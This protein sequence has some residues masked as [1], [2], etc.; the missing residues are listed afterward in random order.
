MPFPDILQRLTDLAGRNPWG[1]SPDSFI[2][3]TETKAGVPMQGRRFI[4]GLRDALIK[5]GFSKPEAGKYL[6]HGWRHFYTTYLMGKLEKKLLKSQTG[7][8]TDIMLARYGEHRTDGD[9]ELIQTAQVAAFGGLLP[10][11]AIRI[12]E[13]AECC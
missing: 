6:F 3:W 1:V 2:F 12:G 10:S 13:A 5:S 8:L 9:R 4:D 7:H 11:G